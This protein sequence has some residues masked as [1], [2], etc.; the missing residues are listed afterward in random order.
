MPKR[1]LKG[2][3]VTSSR[4]PTKV[5]VG[6]TSSLGRPRPG[7]EGQHTRGVEEENPQ[8]SC[9]GE[10]TFMVETQILGGIKA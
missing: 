5:S 4:L 10:A 2:E 6:I 1:T 7:V 3:M 9:L 8:E